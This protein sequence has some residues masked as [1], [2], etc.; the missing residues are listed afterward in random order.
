MGKNKVGK[1]V[2][3]GREGG[4]RQRMIRKTKHERKVGV[5]LLLG[6]LGRFQAYNKK[7]KGPEFTLSLTCLKKSKK[8]HAT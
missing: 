3:M 2:C 5:M 8:A 7:C 4:G 6:K 1:E